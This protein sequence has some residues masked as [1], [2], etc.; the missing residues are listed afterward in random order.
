[1]LILCGILAVHRFTEPKGNKE[2]NIAFLNWGKKKTNGGVS[3][4]V[5]PEKELWLALV[6][7]T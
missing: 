2:F 4:L 1:M 3:S 6:Y 7:R 5:K